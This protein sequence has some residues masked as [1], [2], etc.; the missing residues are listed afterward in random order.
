ME[1]NELRHHGIKGQR[2]GIRRFQ[3]RDGSLTSAGK[4][5]RAD[6]SDTDENKQQPQKKTAKTMTD[7]E[8]REKINRLQLEKQ[9]AALMKETNPPK[10]T[11]GKD[12]V[13]DILKRSGEN[14]LPQV[15]NHYGAK[16]FNQIIGQTKE[17]KEKKK[18]PLTG[19]EYEITKT[20]LD[21]V[22][23]SNNKKK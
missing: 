11:K 1:I 2:W 16:A 21:E 6:D 3:N 18:D 8:L 9:Y 5:R 17:V 19:E 12:F 7:E 4:K 10:S 20:I 14:L 23:F 22:I 15:I 13:I